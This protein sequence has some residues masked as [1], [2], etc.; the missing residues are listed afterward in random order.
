MSLKTVILVV[1]H[2]SLNKA[3]EIFI[4]WSII[5]VLLLRCETHQ[6]RRVDS[7]KHLQFSRASYFFEKEFPQNSW[8]LKHDTTHKT[9]TKRAVNEKPAQGLK[10]VS[11]VRP[12]QVDFPAR[13]RENVPF[14]VTYPMGKGPGKVSGN[15]IKRNQLRLP[16]DKQNLRAAC[17]K[18]KLNSNF[19]K[20]WCQ[21]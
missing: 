21:E 12:G 8:K 6:S 14:I 5:V 4:M 11:S 19:L 9:H 13:P 17:L 20:P 15:L 18:G 10:K 16:Q 2:Y 1:S 7:I 3:W